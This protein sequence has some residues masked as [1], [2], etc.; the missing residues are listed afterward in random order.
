MEW[1]AQVVNYVRNTKFRFIKDINECTLY[2]GGCS[3]TCT[4]TPGSYICSCNS[5]YFLDKDGHNCTG[6]WQVFIIKI[7]SALY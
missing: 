5:G 6:Q 7:L 4:N 1:T 3:Q 2:N